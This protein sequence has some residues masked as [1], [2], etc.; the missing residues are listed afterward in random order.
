MEKEK[1]IK[2][3]IAVIIVVVIGLIF[4][5]S[6]G[7]KNTTVNQQTTTGSIQSNTPSR[8]TFT[9]VTDAEKNAVVTKPAEV[10]VLPAGLA[11]A[12]K[13]ESVS[14][15]KIKAENGAFFPDELVISKGQRV[16]IDF[17]AVGAD[18]DLD[19]AS[20][21]GAYIISKKDTTNVFGFNTDKS[22][23]G[24]YT[25]SCRDYCPKGKEMKGRIVVK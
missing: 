8:A 10:A 16:Q 18:Y 12:S 4:F 5:F 6:G 1:I 3:G 14:I 24:I 7:W 19:I 13:Q 2:I 9:E 22:K 15:F 11:S 25:F 17:S 20:P 23:E 21:I